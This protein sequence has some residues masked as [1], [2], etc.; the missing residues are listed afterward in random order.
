MCVYDDVDDTG[1][2][3][4]GG[5]FRTRK[6]MHWFASKA[7]LVPDKI[8]KTGEREQEL[9]AELEATAKQLLAAQQNNEKLKAETNQ[10]Q[11]RLEQ[12][13]SA[14]VKNL[15]AKIELLTA[16]HERDVKEKMDTKREQ[17]KN[18]KSDA[19]GRIEKL[20]QEL[21]EAQAQKQDDL[22][23]FEITEK[24]LEASQK[25][26]A[27]IAEKDAS[28]ADLKKVEQKLR[29]EVRYFGKSLRMLML[30]GKLLEV[31]FVQP[32]TLDLE[33]HLRHLLSILIHV[34]LLT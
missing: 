15:Q 26:A 11:A 18:L 12:V 10:L 32:I 28:I 31:R 22:D 34:I 13:G 9:E 25:Q 2:I 20:K 3:R 19:E 29:A 4:R 21:K 16:D 14:E 8:K 17:Y 23:A 7:K 1:T 6:N 33:N 24:A 27:D 30:F 5:A